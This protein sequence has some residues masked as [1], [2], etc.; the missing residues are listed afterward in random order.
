MVA[1]DDIRDLLMHDQQGDHLVQIRE[2]PGGGI[3]LAGA[4]ER[5]VSTHEEMAEILSLASLQRATAATSMNKHSSRSHA[6]LTITLEQRRRPQELSKGSGDVKVCAA[7]SCM[8]QLATLLL[9]C[10]RFKVL[11]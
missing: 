6:I 9:G 8:S 11:D 10:V 2:I 1:Q 4:L 7:M 3:C 5:E